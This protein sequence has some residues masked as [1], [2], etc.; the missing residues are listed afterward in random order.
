MKIL[1]VSIDVDG[2]YLEYPDAFDALAIML[3]DSGLE[4]GILSNRPESEALT[5]N[6]LGFEPD[7]EFYLGQPLEEA[8]QVRAMAKA[9]KM[10]QEGIDLHFDDEHEYFPEYVNVVPIGG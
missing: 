3:Q 4:V 7:F 9:E 6:D 5:E 2:T 1:K 8:P 10:M